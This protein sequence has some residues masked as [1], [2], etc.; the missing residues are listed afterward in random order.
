MPD[1]FVIKGSTIRTKLAF[2]RDQFG[3]DAET[4]LAQTLEQRGYPRILEASWYPFEIYEIALQ[5]IADEHYP[6][7]PDGLIEV[8]TF[9]AQQAL[10]TTYEAFARKRDFAGFLTLLPQLRLRL[11]S[12]G[13][14]EIEQHPE[15]HSCTI[16]LR[17]MPRYADV[18]LF[19]SQGFFAGAAR[20]LGH[21]DAVCQ[22]QRVDRGVDFVLSWSAPP[23]TGSATRDSAATN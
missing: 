21:P 6:G 2:L 14:L 18:D 13:S 8:G 17:D 3:A 7:Q 22:T 4:K 16:G 10:S 19:I 15:R 11:Y 20:M 5:H 9:S 1:D 23:A 12:G